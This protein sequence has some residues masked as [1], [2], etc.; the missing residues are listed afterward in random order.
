MTAESGPEPAL[1]DHGRA[2]RNLPAAIG[3]G[4]VLIA[5]LVLT[6]LF[7]HHGF[8]LLVCGALVL[9]SVEL[10]HALR[11]VGMHASILPIILGAM[12][13]TLGSYWVAQQ[14]RASIT[15]ATFLL[16]ALAVTILGAMVWRMF[17]GAEG[18][19]RDV[20]ASLFIIGYVPA[21][22]SFVALMLAGDNGTWRVI[23]YTA[24][25]VA[26]DTGGYIFGVLLGRH[27]MAP[28][29]SPKKTWEGLIGS[30]VFGIGIG[31][32]VA[33]WGLDVQWWVG[34][35]LGVTGVSFGVCGDLIESLIK[36]D[37]GLK[38]MSSILPG[39]GGMMDRLDSLLLAAPASW[40][41]LYLLV[42]GG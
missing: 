2:G 42:P 13:L 30:Y 26:S 12:V 34:V 24:V 6:L 4:G 1:P 36:R 35:V 17:G 19:V 7:W 40:L 5:A 8:A 18:F 11:R 31:I 3:V 39:H 15:G 23:A 20:A 14:E 27:K 25:V 38:D 22:G 16:S 9:S 28:R 32:L 10:N 37:V 21:L 33:Q 29:I 41:V